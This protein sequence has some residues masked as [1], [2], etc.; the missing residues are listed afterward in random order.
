VLQRSFRR[1]TAL[2]VLDEIDWLLT[3]LEGGQLNAALRQP[4]LPPS[5][6]LIFR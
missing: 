2:V 4:S 1:A 6:N 5:F 3:M